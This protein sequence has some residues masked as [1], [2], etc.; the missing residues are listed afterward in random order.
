MSI[1]LQYEPRRNCASLAKRRERAGK[2]GRELE[3]IPA[4]D[5]RRVE[6]LC[7][8]AGEIQPG[9][10][11]ETRACE[12]ALASL[13]GDERLVDECETGHGVRELPVGLPRQNCDRCG[14]DAR[15]E[16]SAPIEEPGRRV[17]SARG[18]A[19]RVEMKDV[20]VGSERECR[21]S[22]WSVLYTHATR[23]ETR[24]RTRMRATQE[25]TRT[26]A[27]VLAG[28]ARGLW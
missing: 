20:C 17:E 19:G 16:D 26:C 5:V 1:P 7:A 14:T 28:S 4:Q 6:P 11:F 10:S 18:T 13:G 2:V 12:Y 27:C 24:L 25:T 23:A 9:L 8:A 15:H 21:G 3:R 22:S